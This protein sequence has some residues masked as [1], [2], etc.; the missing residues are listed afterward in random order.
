MSS[1][2][3]CLCADDKS[4]FCQHKEVKD[5]KN[6]L[7]KESAN[8]CDWFVDNELSVHFD[9]EKTKCILFARDKNIPEPNITYKENIIK[10]YRILEYLGCCLDAKLKREFIAIKS[11]RKINTK[12]QFL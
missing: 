9:E 11:L 8:V 3:A 10:E 12:L 1:T 7:N 5:I 6:V 2:H 4:I